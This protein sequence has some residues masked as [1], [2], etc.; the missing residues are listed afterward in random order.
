MEEG[1]KGEQRG[2]IGAEGSSRKDKGDNYEK[3]ARGRGHDCILI[4]A[5]RRIPSAVKK[6]HCRSNF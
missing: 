4:T 1:C 5:R 2:I 3:G 6:L